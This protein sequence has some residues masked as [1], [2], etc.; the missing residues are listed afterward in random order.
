M[1]HDSEDLII[2]WLLEGDVSIQ[3]LVFRDLLDIERNELREKIAKEG[4]GARFLSCRNRDGHWG[5]GFYQ[6]K[7][8]SSHYTLLDLKNLTISPNIKP[9][10]ETIQMIV[11]HNKGNDGGINPSGTITQSDVCINGMFLNYAAYFQ[12]DENELKSVIDYIL[13]QQLSDGGFNCQFNRKGAK[14]SS[15]HST[16]S[17][18]EGIN[19]YR[20]NNYRYRLNE[21]LKVEKQSQEFILQHKLYK[22]DKTNEIIKDQFLRLSYPSRWYY[23]IL[24]ALEY[25]ADSGR[26]YDVR[27][28]DAIEV[29]L[30]KRGSDK[31]WK[32]QSNHPGKTHF[33]MEKVGEPSRW[34]TLRVKRVFRYYGININ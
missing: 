25:F 5:N 33:E 14:H 4:W 24:R 27:M 21:L 18:L 23:D 19:E 15:L 34:N 32:L 6:P 20:K 12:I 17:V 9:I 13:T 26:K 28:D 10:I 11:E 16:I 3:Y 22:S 2:S 1:K 8:I 30:K 29:L 7:W 31:K